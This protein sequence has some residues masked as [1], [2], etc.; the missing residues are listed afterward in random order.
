MRRLGM[1]A[2]AALVVA[3]PL[4]GV[5]MAQDGSKTIKGKINASY[6]ENPGMRLTLRKAGRTIADMTLQKESGKLQ[7]Q[8]SESVTQTRS[9]DQHTTTFK[10]KVDIRLVQGKETVMQFK[11]DEAI[12]EV[13][14]E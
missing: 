3:L 4:A 1:L 14:P 10:G 13:I 2:A 11:A 12:L 5:A 9:G 7:I 6:P 8:S